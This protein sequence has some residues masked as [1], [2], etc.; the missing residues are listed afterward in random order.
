MYLLTMTM[1]TLVMLTGLNKS[2]RIDGC[3]CPESDPNCQ[4]C[5]RLPMKFGKRGDYFA[6]EETRRLVKPDTDEEDLDVIICKLMLSNN[7]KPEDEMLCRKAIVNFMKAKSR[8]KSK[9][10][11]NMVETLVRNRYYK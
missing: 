11:Q 6:S 7:E 10:L 2:E 8:Q 4:R 3:V 5:F 1:F 9:L